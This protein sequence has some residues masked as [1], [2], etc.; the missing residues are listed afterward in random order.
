MGRSKRYTDLEFAN[1]VKTSTSIR[2]ALHKL[3]L[4][5]AGGNYHQAKLRI[6]KMNLDTSHF[7]GQGYLKGKSR[8]ATNKIPLNK[9]LVKNSKY[10]GHLR[11]RLLKEG[12]FEEKCHECGITEWMGKRLAFELEHKNG[13][14][15]D[16]RLKNLTFL[17]PNCHSQ[18]K[19]FRGRNKK[20]HEPKTV[21]SCIKCNKELLT[22]RKSGCCIRCK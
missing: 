3:G 12:I 5:E 6:K 15:F 19:H 20:K 7:L 2:Q 22:R 10:N 4:V 14:R 8:S 21:Y 16:N 17:C 18:T 9:I 1:A 13:D 11:E